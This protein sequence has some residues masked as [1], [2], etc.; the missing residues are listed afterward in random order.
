MFA[1]LPNSTAEDVDAAVKS[2]VAAYPA[3][4]SLSHEARAA[5]CLKI[6]DLV[7]QQLE[8]LARAESMDQGK[9][10]SLARKMD[11]PRA[12]YNFRKFAHAWQS[13]LDT[14]NTMAGGSVINMSIRQPIGQ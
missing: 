2:A 11:I 6:A 3:W 7:D 14:S 12:A 8:E 1:V 10:V 5:H 9:P 13:L 4:S